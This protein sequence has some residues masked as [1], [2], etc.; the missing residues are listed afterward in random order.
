MTRFERP[1][2]R[3]RPWHRSCIGER[4][5]RRADCSYPCNP[6]TAW[7]CRAV[8]ARFSFRPFKRTSASRGLGRSLPTRRERER[9]PIRS[10]S[11]MHET[12]RGGLSMPRPNRTLSKVLRPKWHGKRR[13]NVIPL[14]EHAWV[15]RW[16]AEPVSS[17]EG[18]PARPQP[19]SGFGRAAPITRLRWFRP[20]SSIVRRF[21]DFVSLPSTYIV[22]AI[23]LPRGVPAP[24]LTVLRFAELCWALA[25]CKLPEAS[26]VGGHRTEPV[27]GR[28]CEARRGLEHLGDEHG[29]ASTSTSA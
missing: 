2:A 24:G 15:R 22:G 12:E 4:Q 27:R 16:R 20:A 11:Q 6:G 1:P 3:A 13:A 18:F 23:P 29:L 19:V 17:A 14:G 5:Q 25:R 9:P 28:H 26:F 21:D 7:A 10:L 8:P